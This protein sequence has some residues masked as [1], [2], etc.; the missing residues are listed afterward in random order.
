[1]GCG[2]SRAWKRHVIP[3]VFAGVERVESVFFFTIVIVIV[4]LA[5]VVPIVVLL[6]VVAV[7]QSIKFLAIQFIIF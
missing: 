1:M 3:I 6:L 5:V 4:I 7:V 2:Y